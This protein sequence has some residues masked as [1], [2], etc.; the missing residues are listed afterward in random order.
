[1]VANVERWT[2]LQR[3]VRQPQ[4]VWLRRAIFQV[5]LWSG[6]GLGLY[7]FF[8]SVTGSVLV[9]RNELYVAATPEPP[10]ATNESLG[11]YLVEKLIELHDDLLSGST[12]RKINGA[13]AIA[14]VLMCI[15]GFVIWWPGS[16]RWRAHLTLH[17]SVGWGRFTWQLHTV[18]G[19]WSFA[20]LLVLAASGMYLC[21][22]D[23]FSDLA[24][25]LEPPTN[26]N[27]G[28][29]FVDSALYWLAYL[30]F[31]RI[32]GIGIPCH[33]PGLCDQATKA[34]WAIVGAIPAAMFVTGAIMWWNRVVRRWRRRGRQS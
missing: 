29:R 14:V 3:W 30:H 12:G 21:F 23:Q 1:M 4:K 9:Y 31:G 27:A 34:V 19:F 17:R 33:G 26:A 10:A 20:F 8:I 11:I 22:P 24:D 32:N 25:W 15:T 28:T 7:V 5:H 2:T 16:A 13:G 18:F 6:I